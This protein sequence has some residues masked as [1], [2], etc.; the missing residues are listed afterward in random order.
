MK[1]CKIIT[2]M[3]NFKIFPNIVVT[4]YKDQP[5]HAG[6]R[7]ADLSQEPTF[8]LTQTSSGGVIQHTPPIPLI[9]SQN[10]T[11]KDHVHAD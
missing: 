11:P 5:Y 2:K 8:D 4:K 3:P 9:L 1:L 6:W 7:L 10:G